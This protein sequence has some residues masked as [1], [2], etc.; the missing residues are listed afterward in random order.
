MKTKKLLSFMLAIV[1]VV[2]IMATLGITASA[3]QIAP[4]NEEYLDLDSTT[5]N[6]KDSKDLDQNYN[7]TVT[8]MPSA[9]GA[10][11]KVKLS[12]EINDI[13]AARMDNMVWDTN[14][15]KWVVASSNTT[16]MDNGTAKFTLENYSSVKVRA[17]ASPV[18]LTPI[19]SVAL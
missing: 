7:L 5:T 10:V 12:W 3:G 4:T 8:E 9:S 17:T 16:I 1:M 19:L 2:S 14:E 6:I 11:T 15:L 18:F 13:N